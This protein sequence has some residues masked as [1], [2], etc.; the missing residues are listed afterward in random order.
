MSEFAF[1]PLPPDNP[2]TQAAR[3][4]SKHERRLLRL[5]VSKL[6]LEPDVSGHLKL[7]LSELA[8]AW[9][10]S[11]Q[12]AEEMAEAI[13]PQLLRL[14]LVIEDTQGHGWATLNWFEQVQ[15]IYEDRSLANQPVTKVRFHPLVKRYLLELTKNHTFSLYELLVLT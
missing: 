13:M 15:F 6:H 3:Q 14:T 11:S 4:M 12:V 8:Q 7:R 1:H 9:G 5:A 10:V 2:V